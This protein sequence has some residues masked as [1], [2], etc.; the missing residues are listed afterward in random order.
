MINDIRALSPADTPDAQKT[1]RL[2]HRG[3]N[4][5][6]ICGIIKHT[7]GYVSAET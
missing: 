5:A 3:C 6:H 7:V 1:A 4:A 2:L